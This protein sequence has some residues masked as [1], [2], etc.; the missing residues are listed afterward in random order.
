V[1]LFVDHADPEKREM[2]GK[3]FAVYLYD[4]DGEG[5]G[6]AEETDSIDEILHY[7]KDHWEIEGRIS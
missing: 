4:E 1:R 2:G 7:L 5:L 3:R 6:T